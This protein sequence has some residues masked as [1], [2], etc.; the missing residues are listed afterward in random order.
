MIRD[1]VRVVRLR[2]A[3]SGV[4]GRIIR[5]VQT[6]V[7]IVRDLVWIV[8][9]VWDLAD[10]FSVFT[11]VFRFRFCLLPS[12]SMANSLVPKYAKRLRLR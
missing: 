2:G 10:F 5:I 8:R 3:A 1:F 4:V 9:P 7:Q 11:H 6:E 12:F